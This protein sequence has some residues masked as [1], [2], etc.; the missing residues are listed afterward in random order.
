MQYFL[1]I[2]VFVG[3]IIGAATFGFDHWGEAQQGVI[4]AQSYAKVREIEADQARQVAIVQAKAEAEQDRLK[5]EAAINLP[6]K[7]AAMAGLVFLAAVGLVGFFVWQVAKDLPAGVVVVQRQYVTNNHNTV[8][9]LAPG[10]SRRE[11]YR[12]VERGKIKLLK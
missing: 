6:V 7:L 11:F 10:Q 3:G 12:A 5:A 9:V 2:L 1:V 8:Q 4:S